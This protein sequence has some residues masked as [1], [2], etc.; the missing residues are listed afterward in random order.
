MMKENIDNYPDDGPIMPDSPLGNLLGFTSDKFI[1]WLWKK[2]GIITISFIVSLNPGQGYFS[3]LLNG[4]SKH[5][6]KITVPTPSNTMRIILE[7][8]GFKSKFIKD[9][10]MGI[11]E[12][13]TNTEN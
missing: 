5:G 3:V 10:E 12:I 9:D 8:K 13:L 6:Y 4:I 2:D 11:I 7:K 1:G